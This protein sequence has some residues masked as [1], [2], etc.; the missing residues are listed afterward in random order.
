MS[1]SKKAEILADEAAEDAVVLKVKA[2]SMYELVDNYG[3]A[4][5]AWRQATARFANGGCTADEVASAKAA[6][7]AVGKE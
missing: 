7:D 1:K 4:L 2:E 3:A 6:L 5:E